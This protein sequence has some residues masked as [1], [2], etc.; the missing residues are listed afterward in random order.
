[1]RA[2]GKKGAA[3]LWGRYRLHPWQLNGWA[4]V[5][6]DTGEVKATWF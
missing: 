2:I 3:A 6:K 1:M 5:S 4:L